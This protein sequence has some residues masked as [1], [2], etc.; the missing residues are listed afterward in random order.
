MF[1]RSYDASREQLPERSA[2][3]LKGSLSSEWR[4]SGG[5]DGEYK[6][7]AGARRVFTVT[8][9]YIPVSSCLALCTA[10]GLG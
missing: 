9:T 5:D 8:T 7:P 10:L 3:Q 1:N 2:W 4:I 6:T